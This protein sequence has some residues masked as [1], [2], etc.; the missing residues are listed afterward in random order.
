[1]NDFIKIEKF[2]EIFFFRECTYLQFLQVLSSRPFRIAMV[3]AL[4]RNL[5]MPL[6]PHLPEYQVFQYQHSILRKI[7]KEKEENF[8]LKSFYY[9]N[10]IFV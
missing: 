4:K 6:Q 2:N 10:E 3:N 7:I 9:F 8:H 1:M 5:S